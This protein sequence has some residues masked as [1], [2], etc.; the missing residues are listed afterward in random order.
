M[1][2]NR[3][4]LILTILLLTACSSE[5]N[6][7]ILSYPEPE[8]PGATV[9]KKRCSSCHA[10]PPPAS[11]S[12]QEWL[13]IMYRM[14]GRMRSKHIEPLDNKEFSTLRAYLQMH[15]GNK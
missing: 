12:A 13:S 15:A 10:A 9:L 5:Q 11:R 8:S 6:A 4:F 7:S 14:Q 3:L 2:L 1:I